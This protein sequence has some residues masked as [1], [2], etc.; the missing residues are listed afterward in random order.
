MGTPLRDSPLPWWPIDGQLLRRISEGA[1]D[2]TVLH[3]DKGISATG[4]LGTPSKT[5]EMHS[6]QAMPNQLDLQKELHSLWIHLLESYKKTLFAAGSHLQSEHAYCVVC[7][8]Q[9]SL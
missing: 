1:V 2:H 6:A 8:C 5:T 9:V 4:L 3:R 7:F